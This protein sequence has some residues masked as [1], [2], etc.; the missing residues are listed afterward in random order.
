[1]DRTSLGDRMKAY[2][3]A[4]RT[5]LPRR[6]HTIL[7]VDGRAF[8]SYCR[9]LERP[10]DAEFMGHMDRVA[11]ALCKEVAG[12][13]FSFTQSDEISLLVTDFQ[14]EQSEPWFGG[15]VGKI[16]SISASLA[17]ATLNGLRMAETGKVALFD[18][19]VFTISDPVDVAKYFIWRQ[20]DTVKNSISMAAQAAFPHRELQG[21][22]SGAL[23]EK[24]FSER[25]INWND[26]PA[27][28]KRGRVARKV[29]AL[30]EVTY[31]H[32]R[33]QEVVTTE[34]LRSRWVTEEAPHF[35]LEPGGFLVEAIP[36]L[37]RLEG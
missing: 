20:R 13:V 5:V 30:E 32:K 28:F 12:T 26:Y 7:R 1:M 25:G 19:R 11:E 36:Q 29:T 4:T 16:L 21:L 31:T 23:Q 6:T 3:A 24:L 2:E 22:H 15:V 18:A 34:V 14:S 10:Y 27:G 17:T 35:T 33:T 37:P 9:G 8:H